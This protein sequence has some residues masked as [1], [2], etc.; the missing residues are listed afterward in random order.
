MTSSL[1]PRVWLVV[2]EYDTTPMP[3][4]PEVLRESLHYQ[5]ESLPQLRD[6]F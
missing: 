3:P 6:V 4:D 5:G 2:E 1:N